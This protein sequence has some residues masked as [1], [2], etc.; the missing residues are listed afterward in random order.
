MTSL[1][2]LKSYHLYNHTQYIYELCP[3]Y[4]VYQEN[5]WLVIPNILLL[6]FLLNSYIQNLPAP[7]TKGKNT[8]F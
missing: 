4:A 7:D 6:Y 3:Y 5:S 1:E 8:F 2:F